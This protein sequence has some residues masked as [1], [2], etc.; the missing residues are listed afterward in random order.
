MDDIQGVGFYT[1][2][3]NFALCNSSR[4]SL[5]LLH[6][7]KQFT[8]ENMMLLAALLMPWNRL[9]GQPQNDVLKTTKKRMT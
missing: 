3:K 6:L 9:S 1:G 4:V 8:R 5:I 2:S 7:T